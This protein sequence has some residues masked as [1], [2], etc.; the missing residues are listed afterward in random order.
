LL[1]NKGACGQT[2]GVDWA[3][4]APLTAEQRQD[5]LSRTRRRKFARNE[6]IFHEGD[7]GDTLHLLAR[8]HVAVRRTTPLGDVAT[9]FILGP[10]GFFGE[11]V[12]LMS[13]GTGRTATIVALEPVET[14]SLHRDQLEEL[15]QLHPAIDRFLL[16]ALA[17]DVSRLSTLLTEA[18]YIPVEKRVLR[19]LLDVAKSYEGKVN[20]AVIPLTQEDLAGLAGT[21]RPSANKV[22]RSA[23]EAG[24]LRVSRGQVELLDVEGLTRRA[25]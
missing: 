23:E 17:E 13:T 8:G 10:G 12:L 18:L 3:L 22:V 5:L 2:V 11:L 9:L 24:L 1:A 25:R 7:P 14:M 16:A 20:G 15:R 4:L 6:V 21:S 19:R